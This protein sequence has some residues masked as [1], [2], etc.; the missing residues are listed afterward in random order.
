MANKRIVFSNAWKVEVGLDDMDVRTVNPNEILVRNHYSLVSAGTEL[1]CLAGKESSWFKFPS[2]PGYTSVGEVVAC[3]SNVT[4]FSPGETVFCYGAHSAFVRVD[5]VI[6]FCMKVP[7]EVDERHA[8]FA[9]IATIAMT[10]L[11][12]SNIEL[13]DYVGVVGM[14]V[15]GNIAAQLAKAQGGFAVGMDLDE[16]RLEIAK[17]CGIPYTVSLAEN[18][19]EE[20]IS[21]ITEGKGINTLI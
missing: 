2:T 13:G 21:R 11:R 14:G 7:Q 8:V 16:A 15:V 19:A 18:N 17:S 9:R 20:A 10:A 5:T 4:D 6:D 3:G 1:A 12:M